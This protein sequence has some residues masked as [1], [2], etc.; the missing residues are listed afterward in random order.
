MALSLHLLRQGNDF[1]LGRAVMIKD[2]TTIAVDLAKDVFQVAYG[3]GQG[4][5][6]SRQR[7]GS[8]RA[9]ALQIGQWRDVVVVMESC[10]TAHYWGRE[11]QRLGLQ[12]R[13]LPTQHV[14]AYRRRNKTD[15]A[16]AEAL[17]EAARNAQI[18]DVPVKNETQ[19]LVLAVHSL[20]ESWKAARTARINALRGHLLGF[21][22]AI[23]LGAEKAIAQASA[24]IENVPVALHGLLQ[25]LLD[26]ISQ[27][28]KRMVDAE[29][30]IIALNKQNPAATHLQQVSGIGP[31]TAS[32]LTASA[33]DAR[34]FKSG[35]QLA[36]W[37]GLTPREHSSGNSR[38][39][40]RI[41]KRGDVYVRMLLVH[42]ARS[43]L[44]AALALRSK[45]PEKLNRIQRWATQLHDRVGMH[46]AIVAVANKLA[47]IC[48]A[49][50][51][52]GDDY[53]GNDAGVAKAIA[54]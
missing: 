11:C 27:L 45:A 33:V 44:S 38:H 31:L 25:Q 32:A 40:G 7:L 5:V 18:K 10:A 8:R 22:Q 26:E 37:L 20:R 42:G 51:T 19:Q 24:Y 35:R 15:A 1:N 34:H 6:L 30:Q 14:G 43:A 29:R 17:L 39:L 13:L 23:P 41:S 12:V 2:V 28:S 9:F 4:R 3:D 54:A 50:W 53:D 46:K 47:R 16:D 21:G 52:Y 49:M 48:W 36:A